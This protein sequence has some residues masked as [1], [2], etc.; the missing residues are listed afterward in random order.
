[1]TEELIPADLSAKMVE[2]V[3]LVRP[4]VNGVA[5]LALADIEHG[6]ARASKEKLTL[7]E[8]QRQ[9]ANGKP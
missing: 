4:G 6:D 2:H 7:S 9:P 3:D 5:L 1:V 8:A